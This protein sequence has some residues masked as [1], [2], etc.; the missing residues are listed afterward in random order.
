[1]K[2]K[3]CAC[4]LS[5]SDYK[6]LKKFLKHNNVKFKASKCYN[7]VLVRVFCD[8]EMMNRCNSFIDILHIWGGS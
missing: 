1:M 3:W 2:M 4:E 8:E 7:R 6:M 5:K